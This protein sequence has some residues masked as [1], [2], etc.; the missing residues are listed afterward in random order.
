MALYLRIE[1][2]GNTE[3]LDHSEQSPPADAPVP[4]KAKLKQIEVFT[5]H[6]VIAGYGPIASQIFCTMT[7]SLVEPD[8]SMLLVEEIIGAFKSYDDIHA[9]ALGLLTRVSLRLM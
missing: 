9:E 4:S 6:L 1:R 7:F 2:C 3:Y 8:S 5:G